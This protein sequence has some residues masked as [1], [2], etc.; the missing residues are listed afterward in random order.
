MTERDWESR[1]ASR[2]AALDSTASL[3]APLPSQLEASNLRFSDL[4]L[5]PSQPE[6]GEWRTDYPT[7]GIIISL[8]GTTARRVVFCLLR[9]HKT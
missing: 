7:T 8:E 6:L 9:S 1:L 3:S 5:P 2:Y 4:V